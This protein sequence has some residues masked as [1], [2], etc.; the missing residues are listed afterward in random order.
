MTI[1]EELEDAR[2]AYAANAKRNYMAAYAL[3]L[4]SA[5]GSVGATLLA[6]WEHPNKALITTLAALPAAALA[7]NAVLKFDSKSAHEWKV[8]KYIDGLLRALTYQAAPEAEIAAKWTQIDQEMHR[9]WN[10]FGGLTPPEGKGSA[11]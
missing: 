1:K 7:F 6:V 11:K 9:E 5:T 4:V 10:P 2:A 3:A 8:A